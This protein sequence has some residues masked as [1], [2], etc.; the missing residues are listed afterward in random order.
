MTDFSPS[1][2][3]KSIKNQ[4]YSCTH[5][6]NIPYTSPQPSCFSGTLDL[7]MRLTRCSCEQPRWGL[8]SWLG[9][10]PHKHRSSWPRGCCCRGAAEASVLQSEAGTKGCSPV[11]L[12][13]AHLVAATRHSPRLLTTTAWHL[14]HPCTVRASEV[15][16]QAHLQHVSSLLQTVPLLLFH[17]IGLYL[18]CC[19]VSYAQVCSQ[20]GLLR[21][22]TEPI[23]LGSLHRTTL[24]HWS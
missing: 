2:L 23:P 21:L 11:A 6:S 5:S 1:F 15:Q 8:C 16:G 7:W 12:S 22:S 13:R 10:P 4:P 14:Q 18:H 19:C 17:G 24:C 9:S 20:R 3:T